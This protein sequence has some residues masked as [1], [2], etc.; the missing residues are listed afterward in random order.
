ML[1]KLLL[2]FI[3]S[4]IS[5]SSYGNNENKCAD[6]FSKGMTMPARDFVFRITDLL[7]TLDILDATKQDSFVFSHKVQALL[8]KTQ[9]LLYVGDV[10]QN[11]REKLMN[12][13]GATNELVDLIEKEI[14]NSSS[15]LSLGMQLENHWKRPASSSLKDSGFK[16]DN[17]PLLFVD[18][19]TRTDIKVENIMALARIF[20]ITQ[21]TAFQQEILN[22]FKNS[23][24]HTY[25]DLSRIVERVGFRWNE[26][27]P[28]RMNQGGTP[29][30]SP[31]KSIILTRIYQ[32]YRD[33]ITTPL[34]SEKLFSPMESEKL[35]SPINSK[36]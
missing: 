21:I 26:F 31:S 23:D 32:R 5:F 36:N 16:R 8:S 34:E 30:P 20:G 13:T 24:M 11:T 2:L 10:V 29:T 14:A 1:H 35:F 28:P 4:L 25:A 3:C 15:H 27:F 33:G 18:P 12:L 17:K 6:E 22:I 9:E 7:R 19:K